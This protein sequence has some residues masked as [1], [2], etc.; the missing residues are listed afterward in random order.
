MSEDSQHI[1]LPVI[2]KRSSI[3]KKKL[4]KGS[5]IFDLKHFKDK[6]MSDLL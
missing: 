3:R 5:K 2:K 6:I 1:P 4:G